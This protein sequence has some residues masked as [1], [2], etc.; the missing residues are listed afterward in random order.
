MAGT[1]E[2]VKESLKII[3]DEVAKLGEHF[4]KE[5]QEDPR[6]KAIQRSLKAMLEL[7]DCGQTLSDF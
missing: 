1:P 5:P 6:T 3:R 4:E 7:T 2:N